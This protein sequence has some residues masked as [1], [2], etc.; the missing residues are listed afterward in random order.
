[1]PSVEDTVTNVI[2]K[3]QMGKVL[4]Q[5]INHAHDAEKAMLNAIQAAKEAEVACALAK[6]NA[7]KLAQVAEEWAATELNRI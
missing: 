4:I 1:M 7:A 5:S 6:E 2:K 3:N